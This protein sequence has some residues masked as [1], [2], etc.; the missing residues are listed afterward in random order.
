MC[1]GGDRSSA[2]GGEVF[3]GQPTLHRD[4]MSVC[5][6]ADHHG[7]GAPLVR[8]P[9]PLEDEPLYRLLAALRHHPDMSREAGWAGVD[10]SAS[11]HVSQGT[12]ES[13]TRSVVASSRATPMQP[14]VGQTGVNH[15]H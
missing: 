13:N 8:V 1:V 4:R 14:K 5:V 2:D 3:G 11:T 9:S 10:L 7:Q 12:T 15:G 6:G